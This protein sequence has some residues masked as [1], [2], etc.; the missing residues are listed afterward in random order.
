MTV[1]QDSTHPRGS[2]VPEPPLKAERPRSFGHLPTLPNNPEIKLII[3]QKEPRASH[4]RRENWKLDRKMGPIGRRK[5]EL[6]TEAEILLII[7]LIP[8]F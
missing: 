1:L 4:T 5:Q 7:Y 2:A 3:S 6:E 8:I